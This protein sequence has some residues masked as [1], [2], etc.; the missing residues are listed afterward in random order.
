ML[1]AELLMAGTPLQNMLW[2]LPIEFNFEAPR[3][4]DGGEG[5]YRRLLDLNYIKKKLIYYY[6]P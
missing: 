5:S 3:I 2:G 1:L 4:K 6:I